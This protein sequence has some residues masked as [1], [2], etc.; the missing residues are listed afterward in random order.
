MRETTIGEESGWESGHRV[1]F[2]NPRTVDY[3]ASVHDIANY[4]MDL[5]QDRDLRER[6]GQAGREWVVANY[7]YRVVAKKFVDIISSR[8]GVS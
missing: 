4:L 1:V 7:G 3:R 2:Q 5:M 6:M 8:L